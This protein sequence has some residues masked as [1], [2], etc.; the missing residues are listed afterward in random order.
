VSATPTQDPH[1]F[2]ITEADV[3]RAVASGNTAQNGL[4]TEGLVVRFTGGKIR[5]NAD[6]LAYG[7]MQVQNL[8]FVGRLVAQNGQLKL[9]AESISPPGLVTG[10]IPI[11]ANQALAQYTSEWYIEDVRILEGRME[12]KI[13]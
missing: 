13:R 9:E 11:I 3:A 4:I 5:V 10:M 7:P 8:L 12:V 1:L 2:V 6:K